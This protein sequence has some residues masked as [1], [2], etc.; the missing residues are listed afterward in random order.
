MTKTQQK[1]EAKSREKKNKVINAQITYYLVVSGYTKREL[2]S[3]MGMCVATLY[4]KL[5][6]PNTFTLKEVRELKLI[7]GLT[8]S[9]ILAII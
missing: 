6:D 2:A 8:D 7:L 5:K 9:Q 1:I 3:M 4:N